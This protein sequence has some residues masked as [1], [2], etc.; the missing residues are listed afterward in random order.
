MKISSGSLKGRSLSVPKTGIK[1]TSDKVRQALVS[2]FRKLLPRLKVADLYCGSGTVGIEFLSNGALHCCFIEKAP[3]NY[4]LLKKNLANLID[5][6]HYSVLKTA[7]Q[8]LSAATLQEKA[9][10]FDIIFADPF[11]RDA[12]NHFD[13]L[14]QLARDCL[15]PEGIFVLEHASKDDF[16]DKDGFQI[17]K[18][19]G[20]TTLSYFKFTQQYK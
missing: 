17:A 20:D 8:K 9:G 4:D 16:S 15:N 6:K 3:R 13:A 5:P 2:H 10:T 7:V 11:Y 14:H 1:P 18:K 19:Y 12:K